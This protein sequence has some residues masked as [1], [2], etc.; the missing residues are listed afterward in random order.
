MSTDQVESHTARKFRR[1]SVCLA[2]ADVQTMLLSA[3]SISILSSVVAISVTLKRRAPR[4]RSPRPSPPLHL[5]TATTKQILA[6]VSK[7]T[8]KTHSGRIE[9][10]AGRGGT[11][12][13]HGGETQRSAQRTS[14]REGWWRKPPDRPPP[15][16]PPP[17]RPRDTGVRALPTHPLPAGVRCHGL[18]A[19]GHGQHA[20][21]VS[22]APDRTPV[23]SVSG[24]LTTGSRI[25]T[26][27]QEFP[28]KWKGRPIAW[29]EALL[30]RF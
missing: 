8:V 12:G 23:A 3:L 25:S 24:S 15:S 20:S 6:R 5:R 7:Q 17:A 14:R 10:H 13:A 22:I 28:V 21:A 18:R 16:S 9:R 30:S 27:V 29:G 1:W 2:P 4:P 19:R 11:A 26:T